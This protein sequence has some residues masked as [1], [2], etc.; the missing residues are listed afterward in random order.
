[1]SGHGVESPQR[2][3]CAQL[4][5]RATLSNCKSNS[6]KLSVYLRNYREFTRSLKIPRLGI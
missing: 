5:Q 6:A 1:M 2:P 4:C 3:D